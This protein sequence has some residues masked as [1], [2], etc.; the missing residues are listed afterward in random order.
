MSSLF[1]FGRSTK[2]SSRNQTTTTNNNNPTGNNNTP[3]QHD[4]NNPNGI[5]SQ[6]TTITRKAFNIGTVLED[7]TFSLTYATAA[8]DELFL[9]QVDPK[10]EQ[11]Q[12]SSKQSTNIPTDTRLIG[13]SSDNDH[14]LYKQRFTK[15]LKNEKFSQFAF[16]T[17]SIVLVIYNDVIR[18]YKYPEITP[19]EEHVLPGQAY[20]FRT[21][22]TF[23]TI[24]TPQSSSPVK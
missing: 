1:P 21:T 23:L 16:L 7:K 2:S 5:Q 22:T 24:P 6:P 20:A 14:V 9:H 12:Q 11:Q 18:T 15:L 19:I 3:Q 13:F 4:P 10:S 17:P 8:T